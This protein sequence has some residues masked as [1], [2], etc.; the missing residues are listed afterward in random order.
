MYC[1][2]ST[3]D[4][5]NVNGIHFYFEFWHEEEIKMWIIWS[6]SFQWSLMNLSPNALIDYY[7]WHLCSS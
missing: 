1:I 7:Q 5:L 6:A 3:S 2:S 4:L